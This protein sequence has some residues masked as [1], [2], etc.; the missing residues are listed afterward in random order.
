MAFHHSPRI[1]TDGLIFYMDPANVKGYVS[2]S[3]TGTDLI[4]DTSYS[5]VSAVEYQSNN[6]GVWNFGGVDDYINVNPLTT[7]IQGDSAT[8]MAAWVLST[9]TTL[10][11]AV[12]NYGTTSIDRTR[13]LEVGTPYSG[14]RYNISFHIWAHVYSSNNNA[15]TENEWHYCVIT[16]AG[17][18]TN[19]TNIKFYIDGTDAGYV[20]D[21]GSENR[22]LDTT[23]N[24]IRLGMRNGSYTDLDLAGQ[25]GPVQ[26]YD[27][28]LTPAEVLQNYNA[29]KAR[30]E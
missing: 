14:T 23:N 21:Y 4:Q 13:A 9:N 17:G 27:R 5:F 6:G 16:Y 25:V 28:V 11:Q 29:M 3:T 10:R 20:L 1:V 15:F 26:M 22:T 30:F 18:G 12:F 24:N 19:S 8:T 7:G 2:G